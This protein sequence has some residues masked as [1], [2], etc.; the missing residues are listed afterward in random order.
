MDRIETTATTIKHLIGAI[1]DALRARRYLMGYGT[2]EEGY[3]A[4]MSHVL[5]GAVVKE[6]ELAKAEN[7]RV[8][9]RLIDSAEAKILHLTENVAVIESEAN[10]LASRGF[11]NDANTR[12]ASAHPYRHGI[13]CLREYVRYLEKQISIIG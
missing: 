13:I 10:H 9:S 8:V 7:R 12:D 5:Q 1:S 11:V 6:A 3:F 2:F 4:A